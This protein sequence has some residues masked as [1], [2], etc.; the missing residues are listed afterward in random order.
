MTLRRL[1]ICQGTDSFSCH[2]GPRTMP[3]Y[4]LTLTLASQVASTGAKGGKEADHSMHAGQDLRKSKFVEKPQQGN[5]TLRTF[6]SDMLCCILRQ[7]DLYTAYLDSVA[8]APFPNK[9]NK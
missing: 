5:I 9:D 8:T 4:P 2:D 6:F 7:I 3:F 1:R